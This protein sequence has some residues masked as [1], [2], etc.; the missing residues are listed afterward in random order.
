MSLTLLALSACGGED[1]LLPS[2]GQPA[3]ITV[4]SGNGQTGTVGQPL[5]DPWVVEVTDPGDRPV[6]GVEVVF[7]APGDATITPNDTVV[8]GSDGRATVRYTLATA[9]GQQTIE[10]HAKPVVPTPSLTATFSAIAQPEPA[11][12]L[13]P[14]GGDKQEAEVQTPLGDSLVV[15]A[16]D[17]FGNGVA[18][19]EVS[20]SASDGTVSPETV[21]T[22]ADGRAATLRTLGERPGLY[23]TSAEVVPEL[24]GSPVA[25]EATGLAP[26]TPQLVLVTQPSLSAAAGVPFERQPVLQ[27]QDASGAPLARENV[28]VTVQI[29]EGGGSLSGAT[30][31]KSNDE[32]RVAFT[33]LAI[34][35][36]P[37]PRSLLFA[38]VDFT[39]AT[40]EEIEVTVG[41]ADADRSSASVPDGTAGVATTVSIHLEDEFGNPVT[42]ASGSLSVRVR[43]PNESDAE[44]TE[45]GSGDYSASYTPTAIGNDQITVEVNGDQLSDSPLTS[46]VSP[47]PAAASRTTAE[48]SRSGGFFIE[49]VIRVTVRDAHGNPVGRGGDQVQVQLEGSEERRDMLDH[50]DGVYSDRFVIVLSNP[51]IIILLNG[52]EI[53][54]SPYGP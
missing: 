49:I 36:E 45:L 27:L 26:P 48:V 33:N 13:V 16:I 44:V 25:F 21:I 18:G 1:L 10:A 2:S 4:V 53:S 35:G 14:D 40:S 22:G 52:D 15:K 19:I 30:T 8:T 6:A 41:P 32:G 34:R 23:R 50:G 24:E 9:S 5:G 3:L 7:V 43:G 11:V 20:W 17:R 51:R 28:A 29:A 12:R 31:A 37:G 46:V 38:A 42:G 54:G 39:P 47:G